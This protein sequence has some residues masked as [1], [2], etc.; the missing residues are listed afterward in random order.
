MEYRSKATLLG[1][2]LVHVNL[3]S[4][5]PGQ[6]PRRGIARGWIAVGDISFGVVL[7][8]GG[9]A[10][11][12]VA[13]GGLAFGGFALAGGAV[14]GVAIGGA[15]FGLWALGGAAFGLSAAM[16]GL[17]LAGDYAQGGGA[18]ASHAN[19]DAAKE[20]FGAS[21]VFGLSRVIMEHSRWFL[22]LALLPA[23][24]AIYRKLTGRAGA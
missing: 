4:G 15:A 10:F 1:L 24:A 14:G 2:P 19:D 8:V 20:Y 3:G 5:G 6:Q 22:V 23:L 12:G 16:G 21:S 7:S 18:W 17:A 9:L 13:V 11:G